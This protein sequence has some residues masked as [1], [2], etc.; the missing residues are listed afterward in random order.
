MNQI[1]KEILCEARE[2]TRSL[3][4]KGA[5]KAAVAYTNAIPNNQKKLITRDQDCRPY[6]WR[7]Y[8]SHPKLKDPENA[9]LAVFVHRFVSSDLKGEVHNH[10]WESCASVIFFGSYRQIKYKWKP[11]TTYENFTDPTKKIEF[12]TLMEKETKTY[13]PFDVNWLDHDHAHRVELLTDDCWTLFV[14]GARVSTWGFMDEKTGQF[15]EILSK[16][17]NRP[18]DLTAPIL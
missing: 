7:F 13:E 12:V 14:H 10:P 16:V 17:R 18:S 8:P 5:H 11:T 6:L 2:I 9:D 4:S 3:M 1:W 15:R